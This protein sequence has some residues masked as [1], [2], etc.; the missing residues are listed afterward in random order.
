MKIRS[1]RLAAIGVLSLVAS[2]FGGAAAIADSHVTTVAGGLN[3]PRQ[4]AFSPSG[5]LYVAESGT[6]GSECSWEHPEF[7][8]MG[9]GRTGAVAHI[10]SSGEVHRVVTGL[11]SAGSADEA[12]GPMD[13]TF[14]GTNEVAVA[15]GLG[16]PPSLRAECGELGAEFGTVRL[17]NIQ[18]PK[19]GT[20]LAADVAAYEQRANPDGTDLDSNPSGIA[21]TNGGYVVT[22][23]GANDVVSTKGKGST[24]AVLDPVPTTQPGP[25]PVGFQADAVPTDVVKG[26]DGA[27]YVS[28]LVG[29]P[30]EA[31]SSTIWRV[32]PGSAPEA[33]ATGLTNVTSLAF[34]D[35][36]TLYAVELA[37]QGLFA[38][39]IGALVK[40]NP[41]ESSHDVVAGGLLMPYGVAIHGD[42]AYVTTHVLI[43][44]GGQ[45]VKINL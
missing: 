10:P 12:I 41:G 19:A 5:E 24:V 2:G 40:I 14:V 17:G 15:V 43:A 4:L 26:P 11:P 9:I 23:A 37:S 27:W 8:T 29:F 42:H 44:H 3:N 21:R 31:G 6:G 16:A 22:D 30:F 39:P 45:V 35:D 28:Q 20:H 33:Y 34:A 38:G 18:A 32:V 36:G 7:G 1:T 25:V 13:L